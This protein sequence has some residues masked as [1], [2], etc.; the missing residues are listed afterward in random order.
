M[1]MGATYHAIDRSTDNIQDVGY[2]G[3]LMFWWSL[4]LSV[5]WAYEGRTAEQSI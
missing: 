2:T 5:S 3:T 1:A 4:T